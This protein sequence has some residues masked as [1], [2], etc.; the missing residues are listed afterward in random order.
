[1][2]IKITNLHSEKTSTFEGNE[3]A[4]IHFLKKRF[5]SLNK[6]NIP[7]NDLISKVNK[8]QFLHVT[9]END[10]PIIKQEIDFKNFIKT[11]G[12]EIALKQI[13]NDMFKN[14]PVKDKAVNHFRELISNVKKEH[15][16]KAGIN[17]SE[18]LFNHLPKEFRD[19]LK[20]YVKH[21]KP[22]VNQSVNYY[23]DHLS[24]L[25]DYLNDDNERLNYHQEKGFL[26][27]AENPKLN[28]NYQK[29][30]RHM[31]GAYYVLKHL[32]SK[33]DNKWLNSRIT[34]LKKTDFQLSKDMLETAEGMQG[35]PS[36]NEKEFK[37][38]RL[39]S[40]YEPTD[41]DIKDAH[42]LWEDDY[43]AFS[44]CAHKMEV[45]DD[46]REKLKILYSDG[47]FR[48][49]KNEKDFNI[50]SIPRE[51]A[52]YD[53]NSEKFAIIAENAFKEN[54]VKSVEL[55]G[56]HSH[57][58]AILYDSGSDSLWFLKPGSG[59]LSSAKGVSETLANQSRREVA[60]NSIAALLGLKD[61]VPE[62]G[63]VLLDRHEV[64]MIEFFPEHVSLNK[65]KRLGEPL[66]G[67]F[68]SLIPNGMI[69]RIATLDYILGQTDRH[70]GNVLFKDGD[71]KLIDAGSAFA[72]ES[73]DPGRDPKTYIPVYLR[74]FSSARF[75]ALS[76]VERVKHMPIPTQDGDKSLSIWINN[77]SKE[78]ITN[79]LQEYGINPFPVINRLRI[80]QEYT[81]SKSEFLNKFWSG[82]L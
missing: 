3:I 15:G 26:N 7:L 65:L 49:Y 78:Q 48:L 38:A 55:N 32:T 71:I 30:D 41:A 52:P 21:K 29:Y 1:M 12:T 9:L 51:V 76:P 4:I 16:N 33:L 6:Y 14:E 42:R 64:A 68:E 81:G 67:V 69:H 27:D 57:G 79:L 25:F 62:S 75:S 10:Q 31:K 37:A 35:L 82:V 8:S 58:S 24:C 60:F 73:F 23:E 17:L 54:N 13:R 18:N 70:A 47:A 2:K 66:G 56:K 61:F 28:E 72:G 59:E 44:L 39:L 22:D 34:N 45:T 40:G 19:T 43:E 50:M 5:G 80:L 20:E 11:K 74:A 46:N 63:L 53:R 36:T 77:I